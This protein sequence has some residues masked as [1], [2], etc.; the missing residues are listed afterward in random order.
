MSQ[1]PKN[2]GKIGEQKA[3]SFLKDNG[4]SILKK[5]FRSYGGEVDIIAE[6]NKTIYFIEV[7]TRSSL[8]KGYPYEAINWWKIRNLK[9][10]AN[11]FLLKSSYKSYKLKLAV[12]SIILNKGQEIIKFYD[13]LR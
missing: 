4:F 10:A 13:D 6:K 9:R 5:N 8:D 12:I 1:Y 7:K 2:I 11:F 3:S